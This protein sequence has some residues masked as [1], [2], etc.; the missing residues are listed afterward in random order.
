[1]ERWESAA[2]GCGGG[3]VWWVVWSRVRQGT[4]RNPAAVAALASSV[5]SHSLAA[6]P[7][8]IAGTPSP[9]QPP[10]WMK[11]GGTGFVIVL[12]PIYWRHYGPRNFLWF[13]DLALF[14]LCAALWFGS[15]LLVGM[16]AIG[17]PA[18]EIAWG[19]D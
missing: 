11:L 13:S 19:V 16:A 12:V 10:L 6:P 3:V 9:R 5:S 14:P 7:A 8:S 17:V 18:L 1:M 15:A 4:R 2:W